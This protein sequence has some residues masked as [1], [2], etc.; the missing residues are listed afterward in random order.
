[1]YRT[2]LQITKIH[3]YY[4]EFIL[5]FLIV[6]FTSSGGCL[7]LDGVWFWQKAIHICSQP[8]KSIFFYN[9]TFDTYEGCF[10]KY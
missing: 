2:D 9:I 6:S 7:G 8:L 1:M 5:S 4:N 10:T 3:N